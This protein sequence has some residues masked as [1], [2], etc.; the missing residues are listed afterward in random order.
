MKYD[1]YFYLNN[2][3]NYFLN[4]FSTVEHFDL[5]IFEGPKGT[6]GNIGYTGPRGEQ[7]LQGIRGPI[8]YQGK[9]GDIGPQGFRGIAG[10]QGDK[11][12]PGVPGA[13]GGLGEQGY[14]G[15]RG[16]FGPRG[17]PGPK[18]EK[19]ATGLKG[20]TG[21][22]GPVGDPGENGAPGDVQPQFIQDDS[23]Q[24]LDLVGSLITMDGIS[25]V[26]KTLTGQMQNPYVPFTIGYNYSINS[27]KGV[28]C[29][30][31]TYLKGFSFMKKGEL[32]TGDWGL[33][34]GAQLDVGWKKKEKYPKKN[35]GRGKLAGNDFNKTRHGLPHSFKVNCHKL[36]SSSTTLEQIY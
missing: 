29:P 13:K 25:D 17:P 11:G 7:G 9:Q 6:K 27:A 35:K 26:S 3:T 31:N 32:A 15:P 21:Y 1:N 33:D 19:G 34:T 4:D 8:G 30:P 10:Q 22:M 18:G 23:T 5:S 16:N 20:F 14:I 28:K 2:Q 12:E 36:N 24:G